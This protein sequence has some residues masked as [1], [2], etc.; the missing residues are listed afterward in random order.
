MSDTIQSAR[1]QRG[2]GETA[3]D[4]E[5]GL[6]SRSVSAATGCEALGEFLPLAG[7]LHTH[8][9]TEGATLDHLRGPFQPETLNPPRFP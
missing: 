8:L 3:L 4:G 5:S 6:G 7:P 2:M 9:Y 1:E